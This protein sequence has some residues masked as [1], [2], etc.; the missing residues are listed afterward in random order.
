MRRGVG[1]MVL[2]V[3]SV[4]ATAGV[5]TILLVPSD[6]NAPPAGASPRGDA[7]PNV[8]LVVAD[9]MRYDDLDLVAAVKPDGG[10]A[11]VRDHGTRFPKLWATNNLCCPGRAAI[12]T[13]QTSYN[14]GVF[15]NRPYRELKSTLPQWLHDAGY[16]TGFTGKYLNAY[17]AS[18]PRPRGWTFWEPLVGNQ[19]GDETGYSMIGRDGRV[20]QPGVFITD[21]LAAVSRAQVADCL[22][23]HKPA[24]VALWPYAPHFGST[25][26]P[27]Y[28][29]VAVPGRRSTDPSL[30]EADISDKPPWLQAAHPNQIGA[31]PIVF[32]DVT[33]SLQEVLAITIAQKIRTL[34][35]VD[36][37]LRALI[38]DLDARG[39][40]ENTLIVLTSDNGALQFEHRM[41]GKGSAYEAAQPAL[42][43]AGGGF[44]VD[45]TSDA[46]ATNLDLAPTLARATRADRTL[47][48]KP[49][50]GR[51]LQDVLREPDHGHDRFL[52]IFVPTGEGGERA[53]PEG[54]GVRTWR[55]KYV[56][57][58][59]GSEELY[60]LAT[61]PYEQSNVAADPAFGSVKA[62]MSALL[63]RAKA[64]SGRSCRASAPE[65]LQG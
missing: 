65:R 20:E 14:N 63:A 42:W 27:E 12:L 29:D 33:A 25:P 4:V 64:C 6:A 35:S 21:H 62:G 39:E 9:D 11:W 43:V 15:Y 56:Q 38:D 44:P 41:S 58:R 30:D 61:D 26:A 37:A 36:D 54:A 60:D 17:T 52:P 57:Y 24:F 5:G 22:A 3:A 13:G 45:K 8:V 59:D 34:L 53:Q 10:F 47:G 31:A 18:K 50:D 2:G 7:H 16:C 23:R 48:R 49:W 55:Y 40:L 32:G 1:A 28:L 46:Y 51:A 19:Y